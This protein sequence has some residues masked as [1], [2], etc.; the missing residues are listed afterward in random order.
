[1]ALRLC[2]ELRGTMLVSGTG[3]VFSS[4]KTVTHISFYYSLSQRQLGGCITHQAH[5]VALAVDRES[6]L[7]SE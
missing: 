1:M 6:G 7:S 5:T 3:C 4:I 2:R